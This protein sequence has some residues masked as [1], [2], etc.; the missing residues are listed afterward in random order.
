MDA[1]FYRTALGLETTEAVVQEFTR[2]IVDTNRGYA[3]F[4]DWKKVDQHVQRYK[5][6]LNILNS[7]IGS[8]SFEADLTALLLRYPE[9]LPVIPLLIAV[10]DLR[11]PVFRDSTGAGPDIVR[12]DFRPR[13]L[14]APEV[15]GY[16]EF[17]DKTGLKTFFQSLGQRSLQD[18]VL[19]VEV[20]LD[21]HARKN[22]SGVATELVLQGILDDIRRKQNSDYTIISQKPFSVLKSLYAMSVSGPLEHRKADFILVKTPNT[23]VNIEVNFYSGTGSKPQEIVGAYT[24]RQNDLRKDGFG[25][26][27]VTDGYG[28]KGQQNQLRVGFEE[29]DYV[30]NLHFARKGLLEQVLAR[31]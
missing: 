9:V 5:V 31:L 25:F 12:Y 1:D 6:E 18:Y 15:S 29:I 4:V 3:F 16:V 20:G 14:T 30:L 22:R 17:F 28:W 8:K 13:T 19:G 23:V 21:T 2:T 26:I 11:F 27:W 24:S 7:L 10:R